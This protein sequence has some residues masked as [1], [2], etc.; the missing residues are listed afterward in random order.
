MIVWNR[1]KRRY[2]EDG[3]P[4]PSPRIRS[5]LESYISANKQEIAAEAEGLLSAG[6][7][8]PLLDT[9]FA[10]LQD[11]IIDMHG[12]A[13]VLAYGGEGQMTAERWVRIGETISSELGYARQF[14]LAVVEARKVTDSIIT[15]LSLTASGVSREAMEQVILSTAPSSLASTLQGIIKVPVIQEP[16]WDSL[17]WGDVG[18]RGRMYADATYGTYENSVK[19][20]EMDNGVLFGR[21]IT[22]GDGNVCDGCQAAATEEYLPL[23]EILDIGDAECMSQCR[24][25]IEFSYQGIEPLTVDREVYA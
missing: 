6:A 4:V 12:T 18:S 5:W 15:N 11:R 23:E 9:F 19:A 22:E 13:G 14:E 24:C 1:V 16:A 7:R 8:E 20:R 25:D 3:K 21:R 17:I 2:E 10:S